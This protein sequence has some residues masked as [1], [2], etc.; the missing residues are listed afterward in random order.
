MTTRLAGVF[1]EAAVPPPTSPSIAMPAMD[2]VVQWNRCGITADY[3][4][5]YLAYAFERRDVARS[6]ITTA[7]NELLENAAKFSSD[8]KSAVRISARLRGDSL[9]LEVENVADADHVD[10]LTAVLDALSRGEAASLFASRIESNERGGLGLIILARDY[11]ARLGA[12]IVSANGGSLD[13]TFSVTVR[14]S[15]AADEV[16]QR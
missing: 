12:R 13:Q 1:E 16:E 8:K 9:E 5:D 7:A 4:A 15:I 3:L 6:V 10:A 2:F 14:A 11:A